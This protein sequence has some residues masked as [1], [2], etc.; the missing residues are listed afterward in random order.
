M[1]ESDVSP[2][3]APTPA[4]ESRQAPLPDADDLAARRGPA[5]GPTDIT[6]K[7]K[8]RSGSPVGQSSDEDRDLVDAPLADGWVLAGDPRPRMRVTSTSPSGTIS[9]GVWCCEPSRFTFIYDVDEYVHIVSGRVTVMANTH[10]HELSAGSTAMFPR[11]LHTEWTVHEAIH[12]VFVL[13]NPPKW[14]R[15]LRRLLAR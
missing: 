5:T 7:F 11:G 9:S 3:L 4:P 14:K 6:E 8:R 2:L 12:K 1:A 15:R 13:R 10:V